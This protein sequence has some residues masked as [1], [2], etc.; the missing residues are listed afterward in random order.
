MNLASNLHSDVG[1][2]VG[3]T[4][5]VALDRLTGKGP[6]RVALKL[7]YFSP[8]AS[9]K[10]RVAWRILE[11]AERNGSLRRGQRVVELTSGNMGAGLAWACAVKGYHFVAVLSAGN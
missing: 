2:A 1:G 11:E 8:G 10:D 6:S 4:P 3:T 9:I 5:L 7:E